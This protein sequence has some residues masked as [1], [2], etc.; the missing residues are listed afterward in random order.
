MPRLFLPVILLVIVISLAACDGD[1]DDSP[2]ATPGGDGPTATAVEGEPSATPPEGETA[3]PGATAT[4]DFTGSRD[5]VEMT[6]D[7]PPGLLA[8]VRAADHPGFDRI[9]FEFTDALPGY[10]VQYVDEAV[11]CGRGET[12]DLGD[13]F[14]IDNV[15]ALLEVRAFPANAH[16]EDGESTFVQER[17]FLLENI[18][19]AVQ[20]CDFEAD[21]TWVV[22][23]AAEADFTITTLNDPFRIVVDIDQP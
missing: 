23:L 20:T 2:T 16:T 5:P 7:G 18:L 3:E 17:L 22:G 9:V 13:R 4:V 19:G 21:V 12:I 8:D 1:G 15:S 10:R 14:E 6:S 11:E